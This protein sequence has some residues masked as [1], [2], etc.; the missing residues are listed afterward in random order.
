MP[1]GIYKFSF[2]FCLWLE[3]AFYVS[4][5][6]R[7]SKKDDLNRYDLYILAILSN[8]KFVLLMT[9]FKKKVVSGTLLPVYLGGPRIEQ[10][11]N[12]KIK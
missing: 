8:W 11:K 6:L 3:I 2:P 12:I 7:S 4:F 9:L 1:G 10:E 5:L